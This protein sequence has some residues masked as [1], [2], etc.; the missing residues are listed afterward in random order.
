MP[1]F[2]PK[3][4]KRAAKSPVNNAAFHPIE[5]AVP[6]DGVSQRVFEYQKND[7]FPNGFGH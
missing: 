4:A 2:T 1:T 6:C 3:I 7:F 5:H